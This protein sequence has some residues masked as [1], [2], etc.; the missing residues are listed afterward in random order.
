M[1]GGSRPQEEV[2]DL[3]TDLTRQWVPRNTPPPLLLAQ[4]VTGMCGHA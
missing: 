2:P 1:R 3:R 4:A